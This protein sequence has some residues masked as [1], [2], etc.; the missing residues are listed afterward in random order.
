M[1][2]LPH[3]TWKIRKIVEA[4]PLAGRHMPDLALSYSSPAPFPGAG[5]LS[6]C[7]GAGVSVLSSPFSVL[8][9]VFFSV[10][11]GG[12]STGSSSKC[13]KSLV[14]FVAPSQCSPPPSLP[15]SAAI[16]SGARSMKP[17]AAIVGVVPVMEASTRVWS[18]LNVL[19]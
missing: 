8:A 7:L 1:L 15:V 12:W 10:T 6:S 4:M 11:F 3:P 2:K 5:V 19:R 18:L 13:M 9:S 14:P 16:S 17:C